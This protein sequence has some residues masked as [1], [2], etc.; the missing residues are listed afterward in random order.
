MERDGEMGLQE[1][2]EGAD[3]ARRVG[4]AFYGVGSVYGVICCGLGVP[5][6]KHCDPSTL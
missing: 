1:R 6:G 4:A 5:N 2:A 3:T